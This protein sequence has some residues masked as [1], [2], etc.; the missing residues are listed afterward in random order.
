MSF[1]WEQIGLVLLCFANLSLGVVVFCHDR[2]NQTNRLF[3]LTVLSVIGWISSISLALS[4]SLLSI[5]VILGRFGFAFAS[6]MPFALLWLFDTFRSPSRALPSRGFRAT[7]VFCI[8]FVFLSLSPWVVAGAMSGPRRPNFIYGP[9]H[10]FLGIYIIACLIYALFTLARTIN[11]TTGLRRLQLSYLMAGVLLGGLGIVTTNLVIPFVWKT[12]HYSIFGPYFTLLFLSFAAHAIIRHRLMD[13]RLFIRKGAV[14]SAAILAASSLF[15]GAAAAARWIANRPDQALPPGVAVPLALV[16]AILFQ[17]LKQ[18]IQSALNRYVYRESYDYQKTVRDVSRRLSTL[19][20]PRSV[21]DYLTEVIDKVLHSERL[22]IYLAASVGPGFVLRVVKGQVD[23]RKSH[24]R[25]IESDSPVVRVLQ[26][27]R[28]SI[29][30]EELPSG[31]SL[32]YR[33][34][35]QF[36]CEVDSDLALPLMQDSTLSGIVVVGRKRS[37]DA[38]FIEDLDLLSTLLG[39]ASIALKN[40]QLYR[41]IVLA[42]EHIQNILETMESAVVAVAA[43]YSITLFNSAAGRLVGMD[44]VDVRGKSLDVL[45]EEL[46][47]PIRDTLTDTIPRLQIEDSIENSDGSITPVIYSTSILADKSKI[48]FGVAI[49]VSDLTKLKQLETEKRRTERLASI[50]AFAAGIAHEIKNPLVAIKTFAELLPERYSD[51]DFRVEFSKVAIREIERID[52]LVARL[53]GLVTSMP[54]RSAPLSVHEIVDE[55]LSLLRGHIQQTNTKIYSQ[56]DERVP[57]VLGDSSQLKQL[58]LNLFLNAL[59]AMPNGGSLYLRLGERTHLGSTFALIEI[60]DTG[61]GIPDALI[62]KIFDPFVTTKAKGSGLGLSICRGIVEAHRGSIQVSNYREAPG[63][64]VLVEI[65]AAEES[66]PELLKP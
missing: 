14:Y 45:P 35:L 13:V 22:A 44:P 30:R 21:L 46:G 24:P 5:T 34:T 39:Q 65:P 40:A 38:Y 3:L 47:R 33:G 32:D 57:R 8:L 66:A 6:F 4:S 50:G 42:N 62:D 7:Q 54:Q 49:V 51:D 29:L 19:L 20:D 23:V 43:D 28:E 26:R 60:R 17:P 64:V 58:I 61:L 52:E 9:L 11:K 36:L 48:V 12:S 41:E 56:Y 1:S 59:E 15:L 31:A 27:S 10:P 37:G 18:L 55:T 53:K 16:I 63:T 25:F 2:A